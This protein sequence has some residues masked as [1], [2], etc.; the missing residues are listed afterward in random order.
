[1]GEH[2][3]T[4]NN[5]SSGLTSSLGVVNLEDKS[6]MSTEMNMT[7]EEGALDVRLLLKGLK[8][9]KSTAEDVKKHIR[10]QHLRRFGRQYRFG[11]LNDT[12]LF[13]HR[14]LSLRGSTAKPAVPTMCSV[15]KRP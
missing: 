8:K 6:G 7:L 12:H 15:S 5:S 14:C 4:D 13:D 9:K 2:G 1:M 10:D 3:G 11:S